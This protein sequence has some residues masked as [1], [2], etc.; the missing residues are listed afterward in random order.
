[1]RKKTV[2][3][4]LGAVSALTM[5]LH[6]SALADDASRFVEGTEINGIE[7]GGMTEAQA[8]ETLK[9]ALAAGYQLTV[10]EKGAKSEVISLKI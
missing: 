9:S 8:R 2:F 5:T 10:K 1:M 7:I 4:T 6:F 3:W